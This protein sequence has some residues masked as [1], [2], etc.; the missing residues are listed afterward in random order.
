MINTHTHQVKLIIIMEREFECQSHLRRIPLAYLFFLFL[1]LKVNEIIYRSDQQ[2][3]L[4]SQM[5]FFQLFYSDL[6]KLQIKMLKVFPKHHND[7]PE[8]ENLRKVVMMM[9]NEFMS[10]CENFD[11]NHNTLIQ[12]H[13]QNENF[14][15][16]STFQKNWREEK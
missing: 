13:P 5:C 1:V 12:F 3:R 10:I 16:N 15:P 7:W 4:I 9:K 8:L 14:Y 6:S 11:K 2:K